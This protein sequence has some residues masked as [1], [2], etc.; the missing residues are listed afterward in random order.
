[1]RKQYRWTAAVVSLLVAACATVPEP[2]ET[3]VPAEPDEPRRERPVERPDERRLAIGLI[4]SETGPSAL[5]Q[6]ADLVTQGAVVGLN[7]AAGASGDIELIVRDDSGTAAGAARAVRDL[8]RAGVR[9]IMGPLGE[10]LLAAAARAR[11]S[12]DVLLIS[13]TAV[14]DPPGARNVYALNVVDTRGAAALG[15][16]AR[17]YGRVG[18]LY[19][20]TADATRQARA[21]I[22]AYSRGGYGSVR[23]EPFDSGT[24]NISD[25]L[26]RLRE[27]DVQAIYVPLSEREPQIILP[28]IDYFG[29]ADLPLMGNEHWISERARGVP[30]RVLEGTVLA[31]PLWRESADVAWEDFVTGYEQHHRRSLTNPI[32]ALGYDAALIAAHALGGDVTRLD[33]FRGATGV[34]SLRDDGVTRR[35]FLVRIAGDRLVPVD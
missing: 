16:H 13:P 22:D 19:G 3:T 14:T 32:P 5:R 11:A 21:F 33:A 18:V 6:Y 28:Q 17:R 26:T 1:M 25:Q 30:P 35:P 23:A 29:L 8:E 20:R 7:A 15:E 34:L 9:V 10:D 24:S 4:V 2:E 27:A 31:L 12:E